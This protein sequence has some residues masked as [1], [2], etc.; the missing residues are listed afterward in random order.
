MPEFPSQPEASTEHAKRRAEVVR[1]FQSLR[2]EGYSVRLGKPTS[3]L[4]RIRPPAGRRSLDVRKMKH[5]LSIDRERKVAEVE[6][7]T[8]YA[9]LVDA[10]LPLGLMPAV[11]PQLKSI[12]VGGAVTGGGIE[13]TSFRHGFV[14]ETVLA[15]DILTGDGDVLHC[16]PDNEHG[17]LFC[18]FPNSYGTLGYALRLWIRLIPVLPFVRLTHHAYAESSSFFEET[19]DC[20]RNARQSSEPPDFVDGVV[21]EENEM[22]RTEA[23]FTDHAPY[24]SDYKFMRVFYQS[25]R[26]RNEDYLSIRDY[27]WRWDTDWFW[28]SRAF[29]M[30]WPPLRLLFG[31]LGLLQSTTYWKIRQWNE[32]FRILQRLGKMDSLEW[33]IQDVEIPVD[34]AGEFL[35]FLFHEV[36]IR[37][38]WI[39]PAMSPPDSAGYPL[40]QTDPSTLYI[41]F[42]FWG[43]VSAKSDPMHHNRRVE[44]QVE[45]LGG[46]KSLYSTSCFTP[47]QFWSHYNQPAYRALK[48][49]Y[50]PEGTFADLFEKCVGPY[51]GA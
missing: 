15:M 29:G 7:M 34:R 27:I 42:G 12:T 6:G 26:R 11:V 21:F 38:V 20:C 31:S 41:N 50:D 49:R 30:E 33:V 18:G 32:R 47:E 9:E 4:F 10:T 43:G 25:I 22:Y 24:Q 36:G 1:E 16:T 19:E 28:C 35:R 45:E 13:S 44:E 37:P 40:Y 48:D 17:E 5:V 23:S 2:T 51:G 8:P 46:K 3:N 14:H 39:C